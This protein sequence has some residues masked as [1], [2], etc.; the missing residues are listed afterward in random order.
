[1]NTKRDMK[2]V[3]VED[4][5]YY[6]KALAKYVHTIC[7]PKVYPNFNFQISTYHTAHE[8]LE[9][10]EDDTNIMIL[11][12]FLINRDD[13][14]VITG[15]DILVEVKKNCPD[16]K[17][18]MVSEQKSAQVTRELMNRGLTEYVD[19]N[20]SNKNRLGAILQK[21]LVE[22]NRKYNH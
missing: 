4:D 9:N 8:C 6:N 19:K 17:F 20:I 14:E 22:E 12:Y 13:P 3:I 10:Y 7:N 5:L 11:D 2:I 15:E 1:M 18:I 21:V 16:C